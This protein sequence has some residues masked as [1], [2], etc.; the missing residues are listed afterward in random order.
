MKALKKRISK[1]LSKQMASIG[2]T[3]KLSEMDKVKQHTG[4]R[5]ASDS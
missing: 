4:K 3:T 1:D 5:Y 2:A